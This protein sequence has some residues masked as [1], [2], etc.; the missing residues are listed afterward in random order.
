MTKQLLIN[1]KKPA[2]GGHV[3]GQIMPDLITNFLPISNLTVW[4]VIKLRLKSTGIKDAQYKII[5]K[6]VSNDVH[7]PNKTLL[8]KQ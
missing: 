4:K 7:T 8:M 5:K 2:S 6:Y 3:T 1:T